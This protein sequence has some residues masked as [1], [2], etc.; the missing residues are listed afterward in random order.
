[1][2]QGTRLKVGMEVLFDAIPDRKRGQGDL[3]S[4]S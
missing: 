4:S 3:W 1:M 2:S